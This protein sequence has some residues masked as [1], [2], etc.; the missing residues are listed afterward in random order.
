MKYEITIK[1]ETKKD[2]SANK[3]LMI[4]H[5]M[6]LIDAMTCLKMCQNDLLKI[7]EDKV[8]EKNIRTLTI[9]DCV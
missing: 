3:S 9:G 1:Y 6:T 8:N 4:P 2:G 5:D 7:S